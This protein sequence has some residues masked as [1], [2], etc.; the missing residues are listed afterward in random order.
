MKN[1]YDNTTVTRQ[2]T[3]SGPF[4]KGIKRTKTENKWVAAIEKINFL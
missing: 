1:I 2:A 3:F 4:S